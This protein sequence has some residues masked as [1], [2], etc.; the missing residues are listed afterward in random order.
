MS[1][2]LKGDLKFYFKSGKDNRRNICIMNMIPDKCER[3]PH[4]KYCP[5]KC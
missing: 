4:L 2:T 1:K 5:F 3:H